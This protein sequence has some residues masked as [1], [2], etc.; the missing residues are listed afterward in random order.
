MFHKLY[1]NNKTNYNHI[2]MSGGGSED[3]SIESIKN[4]DLI[5]HKYFISFSYK[6]YKLPNEEPH[7][8]NVKVFCLPGDHNELITEFDIYPKN[9]EI[10]IEYLQKCDTIS[11]TSILKNIINVA[12]DLELK[13]IITVDGSQIYIVRKKMKS[14]LHL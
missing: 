3:K 7:A 5:L 9:S 1:K 2:Q 11:G 14:V 4:V 13:K 8:I 12:R 10:F 6:S